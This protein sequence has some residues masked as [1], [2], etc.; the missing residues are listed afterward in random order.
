MY[1]PYQQPSYGAPQQPQQTGYGFNATGGNAMPQLQFQSTG[2]Y[3]QQPTYQQ[4]G[5]QPQQTGFQPQATGYLVPQ[6]SYQTGFQVQQ[7]GFQPQQTGFQQQSAETNTELKIPNIRLSFITASDQSKFEHLFRT[8]VRKG[9]T[10]ISGDAARDILLRSGLPP[11]TLAEIWSLSDTNKSGSLLFPE[12]ALSLHLCN[13][14][15]KSEPLP[16]VLPEKWSNEVQS[17]VDAISFSV[18]EDPSK[19]LANT[20]FASLGT[21]EKTSWMDAPAAPSTSFQPQ[22]TGFQPPQMPAQRTGGQI[23]AQRTGGGSLIP[24]QP[25]QTAGLVP[26]GLQRQNTGYQPPQPLQLQNTGFQSSVGRQNTGYQPPLQQQGTGYQPLKQQNTGY[27]PPLQQQGTGYQPPLQ[28]QGTGYQPPLQQQGTGYQPLQL[29]GTGFQ[30]QG[31]IQPQ[32]T[33]FQPQSTGFQPQPTGLLLQPTGKPG[34]WGFVSTPT[35]GI[36]GLSA[37]EQHFLPNTQLSSNNLQNAMGGSLK[38]NV[39]WA[40]TKQEK[41]IYDGIFQAWDKL[42]QGFIDGETAIGIFGKSGLARP[43]LETI[44]NLADGDNKGKLNKDEF[45]VAMHLVYRRLNGFD[46]PLRLPPELI[47]PSKKHIQESMDSLKN[48]LRGGNNKPKRTQTSSSLYKHDDD[49]VGYV[50]TARHRK[51]SDSSSG[52][53]SGT[54]SIEQLKKEIREKKILLDAM[55]SEDRDSSV[56][57]Q[58]DREW[59]EREIESLKFRILQAHNK[60]ESS[61]ISGLHEEKVQLLDRLRHLTQDKMPKLISNIH[62]VNNEICSRQ[63]KVAK[64]RLQKEHPDWAPEASD[65][66]IVG[67][68]PNGEVTD[69]DRKKFKSKQLLKRRMAALSGAKTGSTDTAVDDQLAKATEDAKNLGD[70]Q[71][72]M[73]EEISGSIKDLE[74]GCISALQS[75]TREDSYEKWEKGQGVSSDVAAFI[76]SLPKSEG[77]KNGRNEKTQSPY[78][79]PTKSQSQSAQSTQSQSQSTQSVQTQPAQPATY[80]SYLSPE[81]RAAYIKAQAE[82]RMNERLAKL[83]ITRRKETGSKAP[84]VPKEPVEAP[85]PQEI[86]TPKETETQR[87][88][89]T[90]STSQTSK[91]E[92]Q[93]VSVPPAI[94]SPAIPPAPE[95]DLEDEEYAALMKQKQ[96]ME[97]R[98]LR[99]KKEKEERLARLKRE[100]EEMNK[101]E[102]SDEEPVTSVPTY[103]NGSVKSST[104]PI[105]QSEEVPKTEEEKSGESE[106]TASKPEA[107]PTEQAPK[108]DSVLTSAQSKANP[109]SKNNNPFFKPTQTP[110]ID[111]KKA[112]AQRDSQRGLGSDDWSDSDDNSSDDDGPNRAGAA[113]LASM[114]F[115][116]MAPPPR[117][118]TIEKEET[119]SKETAEVPPPT[120]VVPPPVPAAPPASVPPPISAASSKETDSDDEWGTPLAE[121]AN[122]HDDFDFGNNF[123][124][125]MAPLPPPVPTQHIPEP[126]TDV[127][128]IPQ[129]IPPPP[130]SFAATVE[131]APPPPPIPLQVPPPPPPPPSLF[132]T[133]SSNAPPAPPPPPPPSAPLAV[134]PPPPMAPA[135][136]PLAPAPSPGGPPGGAPN[137][138][139]L[140]GQI[141]GGKSLK[142]VDDSQKRIADGATVGRVVD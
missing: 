109:F 131:D 53:G 55:D 34:Q 26:A 77:S 73:I 70:Q 4:P 89:N 24:L 127:P 79:Q 38:T 94:P 75:T 10:A 13:L 110:T 82:K 18:P 142:K 130:Q 129:S 15:L 132:P 140:L 121:A 41:L 64:L 87:E 78:T 44:W 25:Q 33:G 2:Y 97:E 136:P 123:E 76:R 101:E 65:A 108:P 32:G 114:L 5:F 134:P 119:G 90:K 56:L 133:E 12:F 46:L 86:E 39:T 8:A 45:S 49:D 30:L 100:M 19:I 1:N 98:R 111:P 61:G 117:A 68:G 72:K 57:S 42:R 69:Y 29:Q 20:P 139:A 137:I 63:M 31:T 85:K 22:L 138:G 51:K 21:E 106:Q 74:D 103:T 91:A 27:Q 40:I 59:N 28:Q 112:A 104:Q 14:A 43:D 35:G 52:S 66:D 141:T 48:S 80:S 118:P 107:T 88:T 113:R 6:T 83:G 124:P 11:V 99:K 120:E 50:S 23:T 9:E 3:Q 126:V 125:S 102:D 7:T 81:D 16:S 105:S 93:K 58:R 67:T 47:P 71:R 62:V 54:M 17:F 115:G 116:G 128:P 135:A 95:D 36:P 60:L 84:E 122:D 92:P 96:E 37:M